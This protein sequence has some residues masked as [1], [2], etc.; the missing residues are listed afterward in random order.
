VTEEM[1]VDSYLEK[2][3]V[4]TSPANA[5]PRYRAELMKIMATF[6]DSEMAGSAGF[7]DVINAAPGLRERI[8]AAKIVLEKTRHAEMVLD[9]MGEFG[10]NTARYAT[11][12]PW[13]AR[14]ARDAAPNAKRSEHDMRL[15]VFNYPLAGWTDAVAMNLVMGLAVGVQLSELRQVSY[16][17][18][19]DAFDR[20]A[21]VEANH[22]KLAKEGLAALVKA[23]ESDAIRKSL[24]YWRPRVEPIFGSDDPDRFKALAA[25]GLRHR[26]S[27]ELCNDWKRAL[28]TALADLQLTKR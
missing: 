15:S 27:A 8:A 11:S 18:L 12:H 3:G 14:L 6:V 10:A 1:T 28:E 9:L 21:P 20:I 23:G 2:G 16:Q 22:V 25:L 17:P 19:S 26:K 13:S 24:D 7:A 4:L 5:S